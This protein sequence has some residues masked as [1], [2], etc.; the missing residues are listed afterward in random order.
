MYQD[1]VEQAIRRF[2]LQNRNEHPTILIMQLDT[3]Y[4]FVHELL[5]SNKH[6]LI[7]VTTIDNPRYKDYRIIRTINDVGETEVLACR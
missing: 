2:I 6:V 4:N 5:G 1:L 7:D 3:Y